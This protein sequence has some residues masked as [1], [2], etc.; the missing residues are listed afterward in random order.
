MNGDRLTVDMATGAAIRVSPDSAVAAGEASRLVDGIHGTIEP[1]DGRWVIF[2]DGVVQVVIDLGISRQVHGFA[3]GCLEDQVGDMYLPRSIGVETSV[4]G[5]HYERVFYRKNA[6]L[7]A[8]LIRHVVDYRG[9]ALT[10]RARY[11]KFSFVNAN[12]SSDPQKNQFVIDE[13]T[14]R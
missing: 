12:L 1:Y 9:E 6:T 7:P 14:V 3:I 2:H 10:V 8:R 11:L 5:D 13:I 4:D